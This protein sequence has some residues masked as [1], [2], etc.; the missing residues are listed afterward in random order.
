MKFT[1]EM[2]AD[3]GKMSIRNPEKAAQSI[4][5][6]QYLQIQSAVDSKNSEYIQSLRSAIVNAICIQLH[7]TATKD[8][9]RVVKIVRSYFD[10]I[11]N[12]E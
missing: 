9:L 6:D 2:I 4:L 3:I 11:S 7:I 12:Y 10:R 8:I 5:A 1:T